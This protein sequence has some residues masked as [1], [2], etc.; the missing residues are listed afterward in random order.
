MNIIIFLVI[1]L[2]SGWIASNMLGG[3]GLGITLD[4]VVG[5]VG[6][7][8]GGF[9]FRMLDISVTTIWGE[10]ATSVIG[11]VLFLLVVGMFQ[12][13]NFELNR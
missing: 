1:G 10:I 3:K 2:L 9:I 7:F 4:I 11:A 12:K 8:V 6:A 5:V 13:R